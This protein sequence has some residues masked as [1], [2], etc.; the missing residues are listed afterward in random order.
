M[1]SIG[2]AFLIPGSVWIIPVVRVLLELYL[3]GIL[4]FWGS[5][6]FLLCSTF[7]CASYLSG[8]SEPEGL[9]Y[10]CYVWG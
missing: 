10:L 7:M 8:Y 1:M 9:L 5:V 6:A 2:V 3:A 4:V